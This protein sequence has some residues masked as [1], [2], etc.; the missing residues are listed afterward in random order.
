MAR[1]KKQ[2]KVKGTPNHATRNLHFIDQ[3]NFELPRTYQF[4]NLSFTDDWCFFFCFILFFYF[5]V[6]LISKKKFLFKL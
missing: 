5:F 3:L 6:F 1:D 4:P 2:L